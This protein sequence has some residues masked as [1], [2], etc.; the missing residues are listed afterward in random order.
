[1][2]MVKL[3]IEEPVQITIP[4]QLHESALTQT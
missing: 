4:G 2:G 3:H 1:M